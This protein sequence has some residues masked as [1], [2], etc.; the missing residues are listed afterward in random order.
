MMRKARPEFFR[1][2]VRRLKTGSAKLQA[3]AF[4]TE[5]HRKVTTL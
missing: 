1:T 2:S 5:P 3:A 4:T